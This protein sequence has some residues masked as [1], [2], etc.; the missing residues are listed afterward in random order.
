MIEQL[1]D[2]LVNGVQGLGSG[3]AGVDN[4]LLPQFSVLGG[5]QGV[6]DLLSITL[7]RT[8][9]SRSVRMQMVQS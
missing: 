8:S 5:A 4:A 3:V 9:C 6:V 2:H 1:Q 7:L